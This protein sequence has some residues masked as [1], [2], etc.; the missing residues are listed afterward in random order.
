[1]I[2]STIINGEISNQISIQDRGLQYGDGL[3]ETIALSNNKL[4]LWDD[5]LQRLNRG[6]KVL[7]LPLV[8]AQQ[9]LNDIQA[10]KISQSNAVIKLVLTRG[11]GGRGYRPPDTPLVTR[12]VSVYNWPEYSE[13]F[14][15]QGITCIFCNTNASINATLAG[16]KHLNRLEN[17][18]ARNE[19]HD[20]SI[21]EGLMLNNDGH[22]IEGTMSNIFGVSNNIIYT[23][24]LSRCGVK[25]VVRNNIIKLANNLNIEIN[26]IELTKELLL[27]MDEI[28]VTNSVIGIVPVKQ[29][30]KLDFKPGKI[31][32]LL[33]NNFD[34]FTGCKE[35]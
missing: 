1:M 15:T 31:T 28:F 16:L 7:G 30:N 26:E 35:I 8:D 13:E 4:L 23:P 22:I 24:D 20:E 33:K 12:I 21:Y 11:Q 6:C 18:L 5:H 32:L 14:H 10:L 3:F 34:M 2:P 19:W 25:G 29:L 27:N 9:W 17:V